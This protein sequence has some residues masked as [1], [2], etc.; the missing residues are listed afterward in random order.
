MTV[1]VLPKQPRSSRLLWA[2]LGVVLI[3]DMLDMIDSSITYIAAPTI[4]GD[5]GGGEA[6]VKWLG[7]HVPDQHCPGEHRAGGR[8][9]VPPSG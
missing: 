4:V 5:I 9:H 6:L 3:A 8:T 7:A 2:I 1:S